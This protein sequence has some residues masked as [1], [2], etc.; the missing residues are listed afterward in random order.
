MRTRGIIIA[1]A[2][3]AAN[4]VGCQKRADA[5]DVPSSTLSGPYLG[6]LL[7]GSTPEIFAPGLVSR[8]YHELGI[9]IS[10][11]GDEFFYVTA[12]N[13]NLQY[14]IIQVKSGDGVW[15]PPEVASFSGAYSDY[16][17]YFSPDGTRLFFSSIRP[18]P[19]DTAQNSSHDIWFVEKRGESWSEPI[20][21]GEPINSI[22]PEI[23]PAVSSSGTIYFQTKYEDDRGFDILFARM[24]S[25]GYSPPHKLPPNINTQY[26]EGGPYIAPDESYLIFHS[27]RPGG[28]GRSDL[29]ISF[30]QND[31]TWN[32]PFNLG[33][34]I[35]SAESETIPF[36]SADGQYL[37]FT[38]F[39]SWGSD[40]FKGKTYEELMRLYGHPKNGAGTLYWVKADFLEKL[41]E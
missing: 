9:T 18:V 10:P 2:F 16:R 36:L 7:P 21:L 6:Q 37:F 39:I 3:M 1:I 35:N 33:S 40:T 27:N 20:H 4:S 11:H 8:G 13:R 14:I 31:G 29:Y 5:V 17:P 25:N 12:N 28:I 15:L 19:G 30:R 38:S 41:R 24:D 26:D 22:G 23:N 34:P 32:G